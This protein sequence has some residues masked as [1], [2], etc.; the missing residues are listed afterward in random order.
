[1]TIRHIIEAPDLYL[2]TI[3]KPVESVT[4]ETR[5]LVADMFE[6]MYAA[7]GIGLAAIQIGV[8][9]RILVIDLQRPDEAAAAEGEEP[10][11]LREPRIFINPEVVWE[12]DESTSYNEGCLSV[13]E[14]YGDVE[15]ASRVRVKWRDLDDVAHEEELD[16]LL[17]ICLQHEM[18]HLDG[19]LFYDHLSKLKRDMIVKKLTKAQRKAA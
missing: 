11:T 14:L 18:D 8:P 3:S 5:T 1:M 4:D 2:R 12:S 10:P 19:V 16:G 7:P 17:A 13:P 6:T 15:R 9:E